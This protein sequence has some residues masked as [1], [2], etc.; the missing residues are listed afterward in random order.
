MR[1]EGGSQCLEGSVIGV[2]VHII[3]MGWGWGK[4]RRDSGISIIIAVPSDTEA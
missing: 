1:G 3:V 2:V 4:R